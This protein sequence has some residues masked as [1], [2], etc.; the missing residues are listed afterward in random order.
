MKAVVERHYKV[1]EIAFLLHLPPKTV[2]QKM[3]AGDFGDIY[4][5]RTE[6]QPDWRIPVSGINGYLQRLSQVLPATPPYV[7]RELYGRKSSGGLQRVMK[8]VV[9]IHYTVKRIALLLLLPP[10]AVIQQL[11]AGHFGE[12]YNL[13]T[14]G[15][16]D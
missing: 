8:P 3:K 12:V 7:G 1:K 16:P 9:E 6:E 4:N 15:R 13:R 5:L 2:I 14:E 11:K 10:E